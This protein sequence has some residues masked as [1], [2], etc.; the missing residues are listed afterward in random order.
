MKLPLPRNPE[1]ERMVAEQIRSRGITEA[2]VMEVMSRLPRHLFVPRASR[3]EA[4]A[5]Y[6]VSI[7]SG[8][9]I[10]QPYMVALMTEELKLTGGE[11]VLEVGTGSG[12]QTAVLAEL[13]GEVYTVELVP[14]LR[15]QA[16]QRLTAAGYQNIHFRTGDGSRG[17]TE[18]AP[19]DRILVA[20]AASS[21]PR[22]LTGQ[23][24]DNGILV[25]PVGESQGFQSLTITRRLGG[26]LE[27]RSGI[28]CRFVP[29]VRPTGAY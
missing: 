16:E 11:K 22:E 2:R 24:A 7:G 9:T 13:A 14:R 8:Q 12:Y 29:L 23:L 4:Y 27:T 21:L 20:A 19:F 26:H 6:P 1:A 5:D 18:Y 15:Q 17:W 28:G 25:I 10:S 3:Q